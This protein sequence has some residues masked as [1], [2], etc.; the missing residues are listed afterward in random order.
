MALGT[1]IPTPSIPDSSQWPQA[2][3]RPGTCTA[4]RPSRSS[5]A[6]GELVTLAWGWLGPPDPD[7]RAAAP[8]VNS[9]TVWIVE[10]LVRQARFSE[11]FNN[12]NL[13]VVK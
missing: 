5:R 4:V 3:G 7:R 13:E 12:R 10:N 1:R 11:G 9:P 8:A 6:A 2:L